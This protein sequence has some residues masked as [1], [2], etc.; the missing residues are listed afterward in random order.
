MATTN[1]NARK[2]YEYFIRSRG[3]ATI[4][5]INIFLKAQGWVIIHQRTYEHYHSLIRYGFRNYL[6]I[7]QFDVS[8][9][10]GRLQVAADRR[11]YEREST[12]I[13]A[14]ISFDKIDWVECVVTNKSLVGFGL[15][16]KENIKTFGSSKCWITI[17]SYYEIPAILV[18]NKFDKQNNVLCLGL[19]AFEFIAKYEKSKRSEISIRPTGI[20][21]VT[22]EKEGTINWG[23]LF[24]VLSKT[25]ELISALREILI[26]IN[27]ELNANIRF[28]EATIQ[29][30]EFGSP[31]G[32]S[33]KVD[34]GLAELLKTLIETFRYWSLDKKRYI[35]ENREKELKNT[36]LEIEVLR[37]ALHLK[38]EA[39]EA[40]LTT[41]AIQVL[42]D[43]IKKVFNR[44]KLPEGL[45]DNGSL[46]RGILSER[47]LPA[48]A[49][50]LAG[51]D[52]DFKIDV[53]DD[54]KSLKTKKPNN[55]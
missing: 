44:E 21:K 27:D 13:N 41:N 45:F 47:A 37:N 46:E 33:T 55:K 28:E 22:R 20:I 12:E 53:F 5:Q 1:T 48:L 19:R 6:P 2:G 49:E 43:P 51:D 24:L 34:L 17:D 26:T 8:R 40:G 10:L 32:L 54:K 52:S 4:D 18:W 50:L 29:S 25:D 14:L 16:S 23:T 35:E 38:Q 3:K 30:I 36:N 15:V 31:G 42:L 11:R 7:N 9:S 39:I